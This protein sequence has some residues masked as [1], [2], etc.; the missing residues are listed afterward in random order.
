VLKNIRN[1]I[2]VLLLVV[3]LA[4]Y[5]GGAVVCAAEG[6]KPPVVKVFEKGAL[7][8]YGKIKV[9][10]LNGTYRQMGRQYGKLLAPEIRGMYTEVVRQFTLNKV[11]SADGHLGEFSKKVVQ[12]LSETPPG[13]RGGYVRDVGDGD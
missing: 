1:I 7:Y 2:A 11:A 12:A 9:V 3:V 10:E 5:E 4:G 8:H 13:Y 6:T